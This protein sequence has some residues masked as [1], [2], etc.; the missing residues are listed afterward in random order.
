MRKIENIISDILILMLCI[1]CMALLNSALFNYYQVYF[2]YIYMILIIV[3]FLLLNIKIEVKRMAYF[4]AFCLYFIYISYINGLSFESFATVISSI[5]SLYCYK[6]VKLNKMQM[7]ICFVVVF[8]VYIFSILKSFDYYSFWEST[9]RSS[10]IVNPNTYGMFILYATFI[11]FYFISVRDFKYQV[12]LKLVIG[13]FSLISIWLYEAR[14]CFLVLIIY[15]LLCSNFGKIFINLNTKDRA[16]PLMTIIC[17][18]GTMMPF[19]YCK[20][21][22]YLY[23]INKYIY[24]GQK[25]IFTRYRKWSPLVD[26]FSSNKTELFFGMKNHVVESLLINAHNNYLYIL[27]Y[28]GIIGFI[29]YCG[30]AIYEFKNT[31]QNINRSAELCL[32]IGFLMV[33]LIGITEVS[34]FWLLMYPVEFMLLGMR[35][36][37]SQRGIDRKYRSFYRRNIIGGVV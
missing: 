7:K 28:G 32:R 35:Y 18:V 19:L 36:E 17:A 11:V 6:E 8:C 4:I 22:E 27:G 23:S 16:V 37:P 15:L 9:G 25:D 33:W 14:I 1:N 30:F 5:L 20:I 13:F 3:T 31:L 21:A 2:K 24:F 12:G 26:Y 29:I 34:T 10:N